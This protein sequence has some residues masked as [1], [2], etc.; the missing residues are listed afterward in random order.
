MKKVVFLFVVLSLCIIGSTSV[1]AESDVSVISPTQDAY[2]S[3]ESITLAA[4][5]T[6]CDYSI[7]YLDGEKIKTFSGNAEPLL[8]LEGD[9]VTYGKHSFTVKGFKKGGEIVSATKG[10]TVQDLSTAS[11][12]SDDFNSFSGIAGSEYGFVTNN[13]GEASIGTG[14]DGTQCLKIQGTKINDSDS[15]LPFMNFSMTNVSDTL[16]VE[17][18]ILVSDYGI[19]LRY[20]MNGVYDIMRYSTIGNFFLEPDTWYHLKSVFD[21]KAKMM[22]VYVDGEEVISKMITASSSG[23]APRITFA[24]ADSDDGYLLIDNMRFLRNIYSPSVKS[25][26]YKLADGSQ[27]PVTDRVAD[28][29]AV[30][31][32]IYFDGEAPSDMAADYNT[33]YYINGEETAIESI[34]YKSAGKSAYI[35]FSRMP[36]AGEVGKIVFSS[37]KLAKSVV[38]TFTSQSD[39]YYTNGSHN[40]EFIEQL[41]DTDSLEAKITLKNDTS[42]EKTYTVIVCA[43]Q[44]DVLKAISHQKCTVSANG[45][46]DAESGMIDTADADSIECFVISSWADL[47]PMPVIGKL[48]TVE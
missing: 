21:Y 28:V 3:D 35:T 1:F 29:N 13:Y 16:I 39:Y 9:D 15:Y 48:A 38:Y 14:K 25:S 17:K 7:F 27:K 23:T 37:S 45:Q 18:D 24:S 36:E 6:D 32:G 47:S 10:F 8:E 12:H 5:V 46:L 34:E 31:I 40:V 26:Y 19:R 41:A 2:T 43:Y 33:K 22:K 44:N 11:V 20:E 4:E 42:E 30:G